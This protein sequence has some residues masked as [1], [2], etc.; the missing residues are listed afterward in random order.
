M[1]VNKND[2]YV[3]YGRIFD[4]MQSIFVFT[5]IVKKQLTP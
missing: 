2:N 1:T 5:I 3:K 4:L